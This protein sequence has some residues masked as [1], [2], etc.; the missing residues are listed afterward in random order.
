MSR[1]F[2]VV[3]VSGYFD[4][5][6]VGHIEYLKNAKLL[7]DKLVVILN[8]D[9]QRKTRTRT[10]EK[11]RMCIV[12]S[13]KYVDEVVLS[14]DKDDNVCETLELLNPDIFA[15]GLSASPKEIELCQKNKIQLV[16]EVG[17]IMHLQ[18][19]ITEFR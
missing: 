11:E 3:C 7:A 12:E 18:D 4:P 2:K 8:R 15:K 14:I 13:L 9:C 6:H 19:L 16:T 17:S 5:L 1:S 10:P